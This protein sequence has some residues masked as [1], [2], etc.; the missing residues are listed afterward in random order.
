M[1]C[2]D[3]ENYRGHSDIIA[4][5]FI[6]S[7]N[8][9]QMLACR[10]TDPD[11]SP[12][13]CMYDSAGKRIWGRVNEGH[14]DLGWAARLND[15][16]SHIVMGIKIGHKSCGPDGRFHD[17]Y[18]EHVFNAQ[19]GEPVELGFSVY[20][21]MPVDINGDG[22]HEVVRG[23]PAANGDVMDRYGN[24]VGNIGGSVA[25]SG[26][27]T[28]MPGEQLLVYG[29]DGQISL[30]RDKNAEDCAFAVSRYNNPFYGK[31]LSVSGNGY[32]WCILG[33]I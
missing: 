33:G 18:T 7:L 17:S 30:W 6:D 12:R 11:A 1:F 19:T 3:S 28:D 16:R 13:I 32:N 9:W 23:L 14:I 27:I 4:P 26:K 5:V 21:T 8:K 2:A 24:V 29:A 25:L 31:A 22:Y 20:K 15:D 10:E